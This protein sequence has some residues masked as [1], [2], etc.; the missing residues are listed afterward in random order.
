MQAESL[1]DGRFVLRIGIGLLVEPGSGD[2]DTVPDPG[3][4]DGLIGGVQQ[5]RLHS[6]PAVKRSVSVGQMDTLIRELS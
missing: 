4:N 6:Q 5:A 2:R 1:D 3:A